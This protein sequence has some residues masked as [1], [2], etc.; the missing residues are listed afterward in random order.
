MIAGTKEL[1]GTDDVLVAAGAVA[2]EG[3]DRAP[4]PDASGD[5]SDDAFDQANITASRSS[6]ALLA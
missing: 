5:D 6:L 2:A 3:S 4:S 1:L